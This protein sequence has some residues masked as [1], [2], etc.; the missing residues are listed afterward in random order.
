MKRLFVLLCLI[1]LLPLLMA[2]NPPVNIPAAAN[3]GKVPKTVPQQAGTVGSRT[4][5]SLKGL[6]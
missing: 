5:E 6:G 2:Q 1:F 3:R 4:L